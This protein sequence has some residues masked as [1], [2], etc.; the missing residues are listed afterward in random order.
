MTILQTK[1]LISIESAT[2]L[3]DKMYYSSSVH[4]S[5]Y[6]CVQLMKH[7][8][9]HVL[10]KTEGD[11][12]DKMDEYN[13]DNPKFKMGSHEFYIGAIATHLKTNKLDVVTFTSKIF[14]LKKDRTDADYLEL[15]IDYDTSRYAIEKA[16]AINKILNQARP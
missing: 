2:I 8:L 7:I 16:T 9:L 1:S 10:N 13:R 5:Y 11:L 4:C 15:A 12:K 3:H 6:S 14:K